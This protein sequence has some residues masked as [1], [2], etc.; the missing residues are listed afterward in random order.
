MQ[1][2]LCVTTSAPTAPEQALDTLRTY[3]DHPS[4][5]LAMNRHT[6]RFQV[7]DIGGMIAYRFAGRA[8]VVMVAGITAAPDKRAALLD[9]FL[10]WA[11]RERRKVVAVQLLRGDAELFVS[12]GFSVNQI[13]ASYSVTL[14]QFKLSGTP[15]IKLRNKISRARRSGVRVLELGA[16]LLATAPVWDAIATIDREWI[17]EKG[18]KELAFLIGEVGAPADFDRSYK[19]IFVA[20]LNDTPVAYVLYTAS[21]GQ[22]SG[23]MHDLS[24]RKPDAPSGVMELINVTAVERFIAEGA[25]MLNFG[26]TPLTSLNPAHELPAFSRMTA[27]AF[28]QLAQHGS[29]IY[30]A[31]AQLQ[32][33]LKWAP[34]LVQPE[35]VAFERGGTLGGLWQ[36]L[37]LTRAI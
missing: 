2:E 31:Q 12:R 4:A 11:C 30:P 16:D 10:Q 27:W 9:R 23:W 25:R 14:E 24:R 32:Y 37:R 15:F 3:A 35:Y 13:G 36:F 26:F 28:Q 6:S 5:L 21:F 29:F 1:P 22:H 34:D 33:K 17:G 8:H 7:P 18:A 19:R 20:M